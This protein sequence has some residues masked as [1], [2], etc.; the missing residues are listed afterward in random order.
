M[1]PADPT[2]TTAE[3]PATTGSA[4]HG[5]APARRTRPF[6]LLGSELALVFR[7]RR[8]WAMLGALAAVPILIAVAVRLTTGE[9]SGG[10]AFLGDITNNGLFVAFTALT[11]SIPLFLP[12]TV[13]VV[14]GDTV[15]GE[16]SHGTLRYLLV[17]P[18]GRVRFILVKTAGAIAFCLAATLLVV[19]VGA[20]IGAVLFRIGPVTLLSG[21]QVDGWSYAARALLLALYVTLSML[22]LVAIGLFA[23]TLTNV[24]VGAMA[25]TVVLAGV[26]Q[27]LDQL[28][29]LDWL[30]PF[31]FS[32]LWLGFGDLLRDPISFDSF[33]SNALLQLGYL[34][35]FGALAY[36]RFASKDILS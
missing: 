17:A 34:V 24:P 33:G 8:T 16:A 2:P 21:T 32:H 9:D 36:G 3:R 7:R 20:A 28:P 19:L 1:S 35:V 5:T 13:G 6:A 4:D 15:A 22:G 25:A 29:Q 10:P 12:L 27:V 23:S 14:A 18:T 11:V 31:L 30:H 26:S